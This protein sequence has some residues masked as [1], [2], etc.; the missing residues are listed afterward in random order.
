MLSKYQCMLGGVW[1]DFSN[2]VSALT[3]LRIFKPGSKVYF[4]ISAMQGNNLN[5]WNNLYWNSCNRTC[6]CVVS[7]TLH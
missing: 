6:S 1:E 3:V 7:N 2:A 4:F 5:C